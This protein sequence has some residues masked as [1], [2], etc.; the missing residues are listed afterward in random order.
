[1]NNA[2][3]DIEQM[4]RTLIIIWFALFVSQF[5][6][7]LVLYLVKPK[8]FALDFS[9]PLPGRFGIVVIVFAFAAVANVAISFFLKKKYLNQAVAEQNVYFVQTAMV[10]G[11]AMCESVSLFGMMLA[12][13]ANYRYF[14]LWFILGIGAM[15]FHFPRR[16]DLHAAVYKKLQK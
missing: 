9:A 7:L 11:C 1:M 13:V 16:A 2:K 4:Y 15:I 3:P 6:F 10:V 8:L 5:L 14:F 12:F